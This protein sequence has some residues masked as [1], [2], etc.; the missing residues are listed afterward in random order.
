MLLSVCDVCVCVHAYLRA[1]TVWVLCV[2][3]WQV[4]PLVKCDSDS[5]L[6]HKCIPNALVYKALKLPFNIMKKCLRAYFVAHEN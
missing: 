1:C 5:L 4:L 3:Q 2:L 6:I